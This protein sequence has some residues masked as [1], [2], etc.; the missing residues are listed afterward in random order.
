[1]AR[2]V[3]VTVSAIEGKCGMG[4]QKGQSWIFDR[5]IPGG[6]CTSG[7][8]AVFPMVVAFRSGGQPVGA[9][10]EVGFRMCPDVDGR[11]IYEVRRLGEGE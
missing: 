4:F 2:K 1:M 7:F 3:K 5:T 9:Q 10:G 11:V 6:M 8:N